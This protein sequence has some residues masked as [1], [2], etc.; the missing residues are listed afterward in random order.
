MAKGVLKAHGIEACN[1]TIKWRDGRF[2]YI[3]NHLLKVHEL[4]LEYPARL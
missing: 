1:R 2:V 3:Q 4:Q